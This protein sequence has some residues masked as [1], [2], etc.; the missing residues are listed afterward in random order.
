MSL[1]SRIVIYSAGIAIILEIWGLPTEWFLGVSALSG[2][3]L[4]FASTQTIGNLLAGLYIMITKPFE[5]D[6]YVKISSSEGEVREISLNYVKI[7][8]P[9]YTIIEIPNRVILN[10]TIIRCMSDDSIDYSFTMS[11]AGKVYTASWVPLTDLLEKIINPALEEF[12]EKHREDLSNKPKALPKPQA[13]VSDIAFLNRTITIRMFFPK[14]E[15]NLLYGLRPE[16]Q[17]MILEKLDDFRG[18]NEV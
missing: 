10:S 7:F 8:T 11:F 3:A 2:A 16:L 15:A 4:G 9:T 13:H 5:V 1:V 12:W 17:K 18:K 6:D 14:G